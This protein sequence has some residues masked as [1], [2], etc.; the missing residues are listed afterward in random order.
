M[1]DYGNER[2]YATAAADHDESVEL[3]EGSGS[4]AVRTFEGNLEMVGNGG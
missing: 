3:E 1:F 4:R 2:G